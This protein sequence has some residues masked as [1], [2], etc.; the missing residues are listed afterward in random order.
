MK[1][2]A[3]KYFTSIASKYYDKVEVKV[4]FSSLELPEEISK[5][6]TSANIKF[7][8]REQIINQLL[9]EI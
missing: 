1:E 9:L 5:I 6:A 8:L 7:E 4:E 2:D 3:E